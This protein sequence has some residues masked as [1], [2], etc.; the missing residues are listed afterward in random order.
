MA[1]HD[2]TDLSALVEALQ[3]SLVEAR[4]KSDRLEHALSEALER[5]AA[6]GEILKVIAGAPADVQ[7]VFEG[8]ADSAMRLFGAWSVTVFR[9]EG[10]LIRM[11]TARGGLPGSSEVFLAE[12][13]A[14]RPPSEDTPQ[15][16]AVLTRPCSISSTWTPI[17]PGV[18]GSVNRPDCV[19]SE[20]SWWCRCS[21]RV[22]SLV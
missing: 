16:R 8:I 17:H 9:Y 12:L 21:V 6:T 13:G 18:R 1:S 4:A 5:Q 11:V 10:G 2:R 19:A 14:P 22:R 7:P 3:A 20:P 15:G